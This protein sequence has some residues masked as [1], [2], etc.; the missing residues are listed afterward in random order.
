M[1]NTS[2]ELP[3]IVSDAALRSISTIITADLEQVR[4]A[5]RQVRWQNEQHAARMDKLNVEHKT[6]MDHGIQRNKDLRAGI[7]DLQQI[8]KMMKAQEA[9]L[10]NV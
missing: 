4:Q 2:L 3:N 5:G 6:H 1:Q 7:T 10:N 8:L 9:E